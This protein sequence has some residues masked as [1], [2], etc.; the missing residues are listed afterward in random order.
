MDR[1]RAKRHRRHRRQLVGAVC[2]AGL[3]CLAGGVI[4]VAHQPARRAQRQS[5][6]TG[7][8]S[9]TSTTIV[10]A[11]HQVVPGS[12]D[13]FSDPA[14]AS[15]LAGTTDDVTAAV[16]DEVTGSTS[17]YRPGI[18]ETTASIIK[19]DIL[20]TLLAQG[21]ASGQAITPGDQ[22]LAQDMIE[23]SDNDDAQSLWD[24]EGGAPAV[25]SFDTTAGLTQTSPDKS[26]YWGLSMTTAADQVQLV[27]L[28]AYP[29]NVLTPASQ[30]YELG[31]MSRVD[32]SQ[33]W[34]VSAG[35]AP[36]TTVALKNGWLP[37]DGGGW[38]VNSVGYVNGDGRNYVIAVLTD[39]STEAGGISSIEGLSSL[40]WQALA[41]AAS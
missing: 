35:V 1:R 23:E 40:V 20:A 17:I 9:A 18:A 41:P 12:G 22:A 10:A 7:S 38:Q 33:A 13:V 14:V 29:N 27:R 5:V 25:Q 6:R 37:L 26:G 36:G 39:G 31:L 11:A 21:Q 4:I 16:Y 34:G 32:P 24:A 2:V 28:V 3:V 15:Y 30:S 19:V 8:S